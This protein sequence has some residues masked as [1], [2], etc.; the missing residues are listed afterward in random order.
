MAYMQACSRR[1]PDHIAGKPYPALAETAM[2]RMGVTP[3]QTL[4]VGDRLQTDIKC[5]KNAGCATAAVLTGVSSRAD[6]E[7]LPANERPDYVLQ[8]VV[9]LT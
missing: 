2:H 3:Q 1:N 6:I 8:S 7:A 5:G 4:L 9:E